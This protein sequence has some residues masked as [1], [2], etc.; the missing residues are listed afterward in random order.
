MNKI[1][2]RYNLFKILI[3]NNV[4]K[5][6]ENKYSENIIFI[7]YDEMDLHNIKL[8]SLIFNDTFKYLTICYEDNIKN[9]TKNI[10]YRNRLFIKIDN[11]HTDNF[12]LFINE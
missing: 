1:I 2:F 6:L 8:S 12:K 11:I 4:N 7:N 3:T 9:D 10:N 5:Y